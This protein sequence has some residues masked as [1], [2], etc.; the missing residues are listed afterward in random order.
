MVLEFYK[1]END[2]Y[3]YFVLVI[4]IFLRFVWIFLLKIRKGIEMVKVLSEIFKMV[5]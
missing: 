1:F 4:D 2:G 3:V 5:G